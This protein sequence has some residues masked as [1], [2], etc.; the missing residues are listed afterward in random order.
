MLIVEDEAV[1]AR[2]LARLV[3]TLLGE[4]LA[5]L[6]HRPTLDSAR[7]Q[8]AGGRV[9]LLM[10]D[11][12]LHGEDGFGVLQETSAERFQ[13]IVV[14][15]R[16]DQALKAFEYGVVDF[17]PKPYDEA[18]L[19]QALERVVRRDPELRERL[20]FLTV[21]RRGELLTLPLDRVLF[22]RGA[23]DYAEIHCEDGTPYLHARTL[24]SLAELLPASFLR[25]HRSYVV[26]LDKVERYV[27]GAGGKYRL[28]LH[29]GD[30]VPISR[31]LYR[32]VRK[33]LLDR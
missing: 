24:T 20:R 13:T 4:R 1:V 22:V 2:W 7:K 10:L 21:R 11:L 27:S 15:A 29:N 23:D 19:R 9:D 33:T 17:V 26:N 12:D 5:S 3:T 30:E 32:D 28:V 6:E 16:H 18:R 14:S 31:G 8:I 25:V